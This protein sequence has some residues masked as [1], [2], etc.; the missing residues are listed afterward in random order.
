M[1]YTHHA[2]KRCR[3]RALPAEVI[4][5]LI[6]L[7]DEFRSVRR[8]RIKAFVNKFTRKEFLQEIKN[9]GLRLRENWCDAYLVVSPSG[10]V[11]TAG[12]RYKKIHNHI[13]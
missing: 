1:K 9:R 6:S 7:G 13:N 11:I 4:D 2:R 10:A 5:L 8:G 12:Y 3:Q